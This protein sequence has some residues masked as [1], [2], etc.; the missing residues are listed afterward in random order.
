[1]DRQI[2]TQPAGSD[3]QAVVAERD[4][5]TR[6]S[7]TRKRY[8]YR[9]W[10]CWNASSRRAVK[11]SGSE[12]VTSCGRAKSRSNR[13][14]SQ[15]WRIT[16][17]HEL[18]NYT[19]TNGK[20]SLEISSFQEHFPVSNTVDPCLAP[21]TEQPSCM[22]TVSPSANSTNTFRVA[23]RSTRHKQAL[24]KASLASLPLRRSISG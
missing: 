5:A 8:R 24:R 14:I 3:E 6:L 15:V 16:Y 21:N 22:I 18:T 12:T 17:H 9:A 2:T 11:R 19:F 23:K 10:P 1:M 20:Q 7:N 4:E 13:V